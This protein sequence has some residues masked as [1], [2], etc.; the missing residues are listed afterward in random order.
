MIC[1]FYKK[2]NSLITVIWIRSKFTYL[3]A[4]HGAAIVRQL[5][6]YR[7]LIPVTLLTDILAGDV[8][9]VAAVHQP[10]LPVPGNGV[11]FI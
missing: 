6:G 1:D 9:L 4:Q 8:A 2:K 3:D 7:Y 10:L 5:T 11:L